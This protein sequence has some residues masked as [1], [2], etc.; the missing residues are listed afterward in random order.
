MDEVFKNEVLDDL[1]YVR[2]DGFQA[3]FVKQYGEPEEIKKAEESENKFIDAVKTNINDEDIQKQIIKLFREVTDDM[4]GVECF[5]MK[6]YYKL[7]FV[8][9]A[10]LKKLKRMDYYKKFRKSNDKKR[11]Y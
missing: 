1:F 3:Y 4:V 2:S 8:D 5:W 7:G 9:R 11:K 10:N 6:Q